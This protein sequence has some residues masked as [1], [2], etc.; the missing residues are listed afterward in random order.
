VRAGGGSLA[1]SGRRSRASLI[2]ENH[3]HLIA[4]GR[5]LAKEIG[6][7][8]SYTARR[9]IDFLNERKAT[10]LLDQLEWHKARH[11]TDRTFQLWQ[12]GSHLQEISNEDIM[13][14]KLRCAHYNPVKRGYVDEPVH[15]RSARNYAGMVGAFP[16]MMDW[17]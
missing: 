10:T 7:F 11:K 14:Q 3:L 2:L 16:V 8:K 15:W 1:F 12:E 4:S 6:A 5:E 9:I 13:W 17:R